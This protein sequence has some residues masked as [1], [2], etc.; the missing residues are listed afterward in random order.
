MI[1]LIQLVA[2]GYQHD[3]W[4]IIKLKQFLRISLKIED[5]TSVVL[6]SQGLKK[7]DRKKPMIILYSTS[8]TKN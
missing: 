6:K 3:L 1:Q 7:L 2:D 5:F 4:A 8:M